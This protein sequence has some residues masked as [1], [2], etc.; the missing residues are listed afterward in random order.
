MAK[1][2]P[3]KTRSEMLRLV[4][5]CRQSGLCD[6]EWCKQHEIPQGTFYGWIKRCRQEGYVIPDASYGT[7]KEPEMAKQEI[8]AV[9]ILGGSAVDAPVIPIEETQPLAAAINTPIIPTIEISLGE[10]SLR[11]PNGID[12]Q[13]VERTVSALRGWLC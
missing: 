13:L 11:I 7:V 1:Q 9:S 6:A 5:E 2:R 12:P 10:V 4:T 3:K 8:V